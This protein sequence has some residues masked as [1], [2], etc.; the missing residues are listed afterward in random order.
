ME[1][2]QGLGELFEEYSE[3]LGYKLNLKKCGVVL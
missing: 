3:V 1:G 2:P